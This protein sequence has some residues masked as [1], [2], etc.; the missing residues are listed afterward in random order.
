MDLSLIK[1]FLDSNKPEELVYLDNSKESEW[2]RNHYQAYAS[3]PLAATFESAFQVTLPEF[4]EDWDYYKNILIDEDYVKK[5]APLLEEFNTK[6]GKVSAKEALVWLRDSLAKV[7]GKQVLSMGTSVLNTSPSRIDHFKRRSGIRFPTGISPFD[8]VS[9]GVGSDDILILTA[10]PGVGKSMIGTFVATHMA[11]LGVRVGFYSSEMSVEAV[12]ARFDS[13]AGG[14]SNFAITRGRDIKGWEDY[15]DSLRD[16]DGDLIVLTP[17]DLGGRFA[18][19]Q[20]LQAF[21]TAKGLDVLV[22]DQINGMELARSKSTRDEWAVLAELQKQLTAIQKAVKIPFVEVLQLNRTAAGENEPDL[23]K[24]AGSD[25]FSQDA[26]AVL[27]L[28]KKDRDT[29]VIKLLKA[30]D[31][32]DG[33]LKWEFTVDFDKGK[34]LP[35]DNAN[36]AAIN[37][38]AMGRAKADD[39]VM[40]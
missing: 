27:S 29:L 15:V 18:T 10:R 23:H 26:S 28:Q 2:I 21:V 25:R 22:V 30:R 40:D 4:C 17:S 36:T 35:R 12:G 39:D 8:D 16:W 3:L 14:F 13:F 32:D 34:V 31:F 33:N 20:D 6:A 1:C 7:Q 5:A 19:P 24:I 38:L 37:S 11:S 9:G